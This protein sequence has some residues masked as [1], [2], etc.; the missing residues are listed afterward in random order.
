MEM[1]G[2]LYALAAYPPG[3]EPLVPIS[4]GGWVGPKAGVDAVM[5]RKIHR[6]S[7]MHMFI[8]MPNFGSK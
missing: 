5:N 6:H 2:Q 4:V 1:T 3:K 8:T 7:L